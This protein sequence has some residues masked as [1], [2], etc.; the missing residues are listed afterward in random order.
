MPYIVFKSQEGAQG[1]GPAID[2][3]FCVS[4]IKV[5]ADDSCFGQAW[6]ILRYHVNMQFNKIPQ[7]AM[8]CNERDG[9]IISQGIG[10]G[11]IQTL[12]PI[13]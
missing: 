6:Y 1:Q 10:R 8:H 7:L 4:T 13:G 9:G 2:L 5:D 12:E 11:I 3:V